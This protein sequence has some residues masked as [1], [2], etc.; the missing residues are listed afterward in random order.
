M[1]VELK[2]IAGPHRGKS[3]VFDEHQTFLV[4]RGSRA[5]FQLETADP[6]FSRE[7]FL[8]EINPPRCRLFDLES[9]NGTLVNKRR[10]QEID[11]FDGDVIC[12]GKTAL[13]VNIEEHQRDEF[14]AITGTNRMVQRT[15]SP[16][17]DVAPAVPELTP[18]SGIDEADALSLPVPDSNQKGLQKTRRSNSTP[19]L[20]IPQP[21]GKGDLETDLLVPGFQVL[22][23]IGEGGMGVVYHVM[24]KEDRQ[25]FAL[26]TIHPDK[27]ASKRELELFFREI[28]ILQTLNHPRIVR[29]HEMGHVEDELYFLMEYIPGID[30]DQFY[31]KEGTLPISVATRICCEILDG[32]EHAHN[33]GYVHRDIKPGNMLNADNGNHRGSCLAD[34]GLAR[35]YQ[36]SQLSGLTISG[37][38]GGS[39]AYMAPDQLTN[40]RNATPACDVYSVTASLYTMLT[41]KFVYDFTGSASQAVARILKG[42][43]TPITEHRSDI[44][45]KLVNVIAKGLEPK[46]E[47]RIPEAWKLKKLLLPFAEFE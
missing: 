45:K 14:P 39:L 33:L 4:G 13:R 24:R 25:Q 18:A 21:E 29:F 7:H 30:A 38:V 5:H 42:N 1:R 44:P 32:L 10:I 26:K 19:E 28:E 16:D 37:E 41:G 47:N 43:P 40:F 23:K 31:K 34:F 35:A 46:P 2:V 8:I 6:W 27:A 12:G 20:K 15:Q 3:F 17:D 36:T 9:R 11:L 22:R